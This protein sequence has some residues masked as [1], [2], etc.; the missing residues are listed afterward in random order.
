MLTARIRKRLLVVLLAGLMSALLAGPPASAFSYATTGQPGYVSLPAVKGVHLNVCAYGCFQPA[1][2]VSGPTVYRSPASSGAQLV[3]LTYTLKTWSNGWMNQINESAQYTIP[4][5]QNTVLTNEK[6]W[7][8]NTGGY[9]Q[10][11]MTVSHIDIQTNTALGIRSIVMDQQGDYVCETR[12][13]CEAG[14]GWVF[15]R[16]P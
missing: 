4:A 8:P 2:I 12:F 1:L 16:E 9:K 11:W 6:S 10:V 3:Y 7:L 5:G 15:I 14:P 13:P